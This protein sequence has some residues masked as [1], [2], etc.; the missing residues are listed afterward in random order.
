MGVWGPIRR[1][2]EQEDGCESA[3]HNKPRCLI[4]AGF[5][6]AGLGAAWISLAVLAVSE[7][8]VGRNKIA[9]AMALSS[10]VLALLFKRV[11]EWRMKRLI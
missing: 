11:F 1:A 9:L 7:L 4:L 5:A 3:N 6:T 2:V 10:I 8:F